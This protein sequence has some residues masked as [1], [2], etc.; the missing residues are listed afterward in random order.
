MPNK[1]LIDLRFATRQF[2]RS[3]GFTIL[4][5]L[6]IAIGITATTVIFSLVNAV[7]LQPLPL[8]HPEQLV[9]LATLERPAGSTGPSTIR[10]DTSYPNFYDW[11]S[12][13]KSFSSMASDNTGG[14]I[15]APGGGAAGNNPAR[16]L[17]SAQ[18]SSDFFSTIG[19]SPELGR[20]FTKAKD[21]PGSRAVVLSH[22]IWQS[23]FAGDR[24]I[25][26]KTIILSERGY[27][28]VGIM[29]KGLA[30]PVTHND[31]FWVNMAPDAEGKN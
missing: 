16:R 13:N 24:S 23:D 10:N 14:L 29:P 6:T 30:F 21:R 26:G 2:R 12:L 27:I 1:W 28:V 17:P 15:L 5:L 11:R 20:G 31:A 4:V 22:D 18:V 19:V 8:P 9:S 3:S 25:L 7:L